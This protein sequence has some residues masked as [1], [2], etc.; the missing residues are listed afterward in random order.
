MIKKN[1]PNMITSGNLI[2]GCI[3]VYF[4][5]NGEF[6]LAAY[7]IG[8]AALFDFLDGLV[9]RL[10]KVHSEIGKQLDSLADMVTF[11]VLPSFI[12]FQ[13]MTEA[14]AGNWKF[15]AF[16][17]A[18][19]SAFRLAKFNIDTRQSDQFIGLPTPANAIFICS[20]IFLKDIPGFDFLFEKTALSIVVTIFSLLLVAEIPMIALKFKS[21]KFKENIFRYILILGAITLVV[22]FQFSGIPFVIAFY[23]LLSVVNNIV[24]SR[25]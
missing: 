23:I 21:L 10:L 1:I 17:I 14:D 20:L 25:N 4:T 8:L 9:A 13:Y 22:L 15:I 12:M 18:V 5:L 6:M 24:A 3:G 11:G 19:F 2:A 16:A 7:C